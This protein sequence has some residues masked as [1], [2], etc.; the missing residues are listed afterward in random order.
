M[1]HCAYCGLRTV[2]WLR[3]VFYFIGH[4]GITKINT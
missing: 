1:I 3:K 2:N 4:G